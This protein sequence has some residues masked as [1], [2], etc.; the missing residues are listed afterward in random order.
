MG[1]KTLMAYA[2]N[3]LSL[4]EAKL[5]LKLE[6]ASSPPNDRINDALYS[7]SQEINNY[8]ERELISTAWI[9]YHER[10]SAAPSVLRV[11]H[12]P[13]TSPITEIAEDTSRAYGATTVLTENTDFLV[14]YNTG[15]I[16]RVSGGSPTTWFSGFEAIR[17]KLTGGWSEANVPPAVKDVCKEYMARK[18]HAGVDQEYSFSTV[19]DARGTVTHFGP[20]MLTKPMKMRMSEYKDHRSTT[21][22]RYTTA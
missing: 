21:C 14:N 9:E 6:G 4:E 19:N 17:I 20:V 16:T 12:W 13:P 7:S 8:L 18:Y 2:Y 22:V 15:E 10:S 5:A 1:V 3:L 11:L